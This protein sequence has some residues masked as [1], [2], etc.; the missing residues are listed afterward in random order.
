MDYSFQIVCVQTS[1]PPPQPHLGKNRK[2]GVC[3]VGGD[4]TQAYNRICLQVNGPIAGAAYKK[5]AGEGSYKRQF[6]V[7]G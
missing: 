3:G 1:P 4:F 7:L 2:R 5:G 6:T